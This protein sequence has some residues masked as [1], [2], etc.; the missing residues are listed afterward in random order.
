ML[1]RLPGLA[2]VN[3]GLRNIWKFP[4]FVSSGRALRDA[5]SKD[6]GGRGMEEEHMG[7][8]LQLI[9][10]C[11]TLPHLHPPLTKGRMLAKDTSEQVRGA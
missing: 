3:E 9:A 7:F 2:W 1:V 6:R 8:T 11:A 5:A 4:S 10:I